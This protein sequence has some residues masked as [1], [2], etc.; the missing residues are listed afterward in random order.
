MCLHSQ[1]AVE[2][3][4]CVGKHFANWQCFPCAGIR[5]DNLDLPPNS[6]LCGPRKKYQLC[7][8]PQ[9]P[10]EE[11]GRSTQCGSISGHNLRASCLSNRG[12]Q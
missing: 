11:S 8:S 10:S 6:S 2:P 1:E 9:V 3:G 12:L 4:R 5:G 7:P